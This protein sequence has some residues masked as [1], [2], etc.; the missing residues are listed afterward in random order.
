MFFYPLKVRPRHPLEVNAFERQ[1]APKA[2]HYGVSQPVVL[3]AAERGLPEEDE[4]QGQK[5]PLAPC[6]TLDL[7]D[8]CPM[9]T[10]CPSCLMA[11]QELFEKADG[12]KEGPER[13]VAVMG[14]HAQDRARAC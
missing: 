5:D 9:E 2:C 6:P 3:I 4:T 8:S 1:Q 10:D 12:P 13:T 11:A 7:N 14:S